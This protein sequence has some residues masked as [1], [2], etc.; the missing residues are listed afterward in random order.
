MKKLIPIYAILSLAICYFTQ[1][2][3]NSRW[4]VWNLPSP[5]VKFTLI[6]YVFMLIYVSAL[7]FMMDY[8]SKKKGKTEK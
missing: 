5:V 7:L 8:A 6:L 3:L 2:Y 1:A 4:D